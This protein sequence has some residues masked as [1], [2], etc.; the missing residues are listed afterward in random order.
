MNWF[1]NLI[2]WDRK[3][4]KKRQKNKTQVINKDYQCV[5]LIAKSE[6]IESHIKKGGYDYRI[7]S[8]VHV[9]NMGLA[10]NLSSQLD[11]PEIRREITRIYN[12]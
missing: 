1:D 12:A 8:F 6:S 3:K 11:L 4:L 10:E 5:C 9:I 7:E 2:E